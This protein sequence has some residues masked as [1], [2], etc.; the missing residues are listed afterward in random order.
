[1]KRSHKYLLSTHLHIVINSYF[2]CINFVTFLDEV[3]GKLI[4]LYLCEII[5]AS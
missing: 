4:L 5:F 3:R 2:E 1:M